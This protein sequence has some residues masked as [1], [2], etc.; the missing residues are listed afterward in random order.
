MWKFILF[1]I[2]G[3]IIIWQLGLFQ[4]PS[5]KTPQA[6]IATKPTAQKENRHVVQKEQKESPKEEI[7]QEKKERQTEIKKEALSSLLSGK[8][9][10]ISI[11]PAKEESKKEKLKEIVKSESKTDNYQNMLEAEASNDMR[12]DNAV[13]VKG[14]KTLTPPAQ[15]KS[16]YESMLEAEAKDSAGDN[17]VRLSSAPKVTSK[18]KLQDKKKE[19]S[20]ED[21]E[22]QSAPKPAI[23]DDKTAKVLL[24]E[25]LKKL[26]MGAGIEIKDKKLASLLA[27]ETPTDNAVKVKPES[28][29]DLIKDIIQEISKDPKSKN[30]YVVGLLKEVSQSKIDI[31]EVGKDF[32]VVKIKEGDNLWNIAKKIYGDGFKYKLIYEANKDKLSDPNVV[33]VG[34]IIK[35]PKSK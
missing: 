24:R 6:P 16:S 19:P 11:A 33:P 15:K 22:S 1:I 31:L 25:N 5:V 28:K 21:I 9:Q 3:S 27:E 4:T 18:P 23:K 7:R 20:L 14:T 17:V 30:S 12:S 32:T 26:I 35:V 2:V 34:T 8:T 10:S 29:K 13:V